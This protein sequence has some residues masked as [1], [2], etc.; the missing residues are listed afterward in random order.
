MRKQIVLASLAVVAGLAALTA[1]PAGATPRRMNGQ[2]A[3]ARFDPAL[4]D[5]RFY[6]INP[7]GSHERRV[8]PRALEC[9]HWS[10]DGTLIAS[11]G[12]PN[13]GAT[14]LINPDT[15]AVR[16]LPEPDPGL[17]L[18]CATWSP[19]GK[20]LACE[21][22]TDPADPNRNGIY[23]IRSSDGGG[24]ERMTI[25]HG[26]HDAAGDYSPDGR[27]F[28]FVRAD[29]NSN[30]IAMFVV[31]VNGTGLRQITPDGT[32][33]SSF[34]SWSPQ[35]NEIAFS[36]H[37]NGDVHSSLWIVHPNGTGL[38]EIHVR[39]VD[40]GGRNDDPNGI[41]CFDPH[42]SP[43]GTKIAF[44]LASAAGRNIYT[45]NADGSGLTQ[46]SHGGADDSPDW[47]THPLAR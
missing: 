3:F 42:W 25:N 4:G 17:P 40:C 37:V 23:S 34:G 29:A 8:L 10:P 26:G 22:F 24:L 35:G 27:H 28:V 47:G 1:F 46:V 6:T 21:L 32:L 16:S 44:G 15:G 19:N 36:R 41:A 13:G 30:P 45:I 31:N 14:L 7:D 38:R 20:R 12:D 18:A 5:S 33:L 39:G 2:I 43:D 9:P 11:C